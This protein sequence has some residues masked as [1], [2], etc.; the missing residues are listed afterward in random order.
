MLEALS[1]LG[2]TLI[3]TESKNPRALPQ[4]NLPV[5]PNGTSNM[6]NPTQIRPRL[7][8]A[9]SRSRA[10]TALFSSPAPSIFW[11]SSVTTATTSNVREKIGVFAVAIFVLV[12]VV[13]GAFAAGY[14][15]GRILL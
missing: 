6:S 15:I 2:R 7:A 14:L 1:V 9:R 3:A 8:A 11:P 5:V 12:V 10:T 4:G 13:G